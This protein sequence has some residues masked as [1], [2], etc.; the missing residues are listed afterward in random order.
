MSNEELYK[1]LADAIVSCKKD[2]VIAAVE[3]ARG[4]LSA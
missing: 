3:K 2:A 4:K 1:E